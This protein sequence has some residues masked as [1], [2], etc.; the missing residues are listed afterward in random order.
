M[1]A[2]AAHRRWR[3]FASRLQ[4]LARIGRVVLRAKR[5]HERLPVVEAALADANSWVSG[6]EKASRAW[7]AHAAVDTAI[8]RC[9]GASERNRLRAQRAAATIKQAHSKPPA[10]Y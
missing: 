10:R 8:A 5:A 3:A 1:D 7:H 4:T 6:G 9:A 2:A